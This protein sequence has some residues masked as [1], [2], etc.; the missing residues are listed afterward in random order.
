M[1]ALNWNTIENTI[2]AWVVAATGLPADRVIWS[3]QG[4]PRP[5]TPYISLLTTSI[6]PIGRDW[7]SVKSAPE[8]LPGA[9]LILQSR[10]HR[11]CTISIQC[12]GNGSLEVLGDLAGSI[13]LFTLQLNQ[14]GVGVAGF[15][16]ITMIGEARL[17]SF[18]EPRAVTELQFHV[19]SDLEIPITFIEKVEITNENRSET[20]V[21]DLGGTG[22]W[23][24]GYSDGF[25]E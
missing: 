10:G 11:T 24:D 22:S 16:P 9:E 12:F 19:K 17:G 6:T 15:N 14:G 4:G 5:S 13:P 25:G 20:T 3:Q 23:S 18:L 2:H 8:P 21:V 7:G 1:S